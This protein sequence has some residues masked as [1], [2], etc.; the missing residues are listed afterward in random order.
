[1]LNYIKKEILHYDDSMKLSPYVSYKINEL[2][3]E[4]TKMIY[5]YK[6]ILYSFMI[7]K[8]KIEYAF[9]T[10]VFTGE[11]HKINYMMIV[12]AKSMNDIKTKVLAYQK[13][14]KIKEDNKNKSQYLQDNNV[15]NGSGN[16]VS[17]TADIVLKGDDDIWEIH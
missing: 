3:F 5:T 17:K 6:M 9:S 11:E 10:K 12:V 13:Q 7:N 4:K 8:K 14:E 2:A 16:Y 15:L 1:M